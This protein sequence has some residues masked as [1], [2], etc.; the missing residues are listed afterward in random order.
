MQPMATIEIPSVHDV[1]QTIPLER[2]KVLT[3]EKELLNG[4]KKEVLHEMWGFV[5]INRLPFCFRAWPSIVHTR[6]D[7]LD[8]VTRWG[9]PHVPENPLYFRI[10]ILIQPITDDDRVYMLAG[11]KKVKGS[12]ISRVS[13]SGRIPEL[14][15]AELE[16]RSRAYREFFEFYDENKEMRRVYG[17]A[18]SSVCDEK[19]AQLHSLS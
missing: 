9:F 11:L 12:K 15:K 8:T 5:W 14:F 4:T 17:N 6:L 10:P 3:L 2:I 13:S 1:I 19:E 16:K 7:L 18:V